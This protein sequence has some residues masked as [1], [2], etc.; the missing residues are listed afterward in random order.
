MP[1]ANRTREFEI[2][3][4]FYSF[5]V[6]AHFTE[7]NASQESKSRRPHTHHIDTERIDRAEK[8]VSISFTPSALLLIVMDVDDLG[9]PVSA[10]RRVLA[11]ATQR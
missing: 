2:Q 3:K 11:E 4:L 10:L 5:K 1:N 6:D 9:G 8:I 7:S